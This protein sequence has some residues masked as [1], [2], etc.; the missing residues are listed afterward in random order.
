MEESKTPRQPADEAG[1]QQPMDEARWQIVESLLRRLAC[2]LTRAADGRSARLDD[3]LEETR[4]CLRKPSEPPVLEE[5]LTRLGEAIKALDEPAAAART[6]A[7][8]SPG[9]A[10]PLG[11]IVQVL[12]DLLDRLELDDAAEE[13]DQLRGAL[14][15]VRDQTALAAQVEALA[16]LLNRHCVRLGQQR[17][18][19]EKLLQQ[20]NEQLDE[21]AAFLVD[22]NQAHQSGMDSRQA[23]DSGVMGEMRALKDNVQATDDLGALRKGVELRIGAVTVHLQQFRQREEQRE[24]EWQARNHAMSERIT[25]LEHSTGELKTSLRHEQHLAA[26]DRLTGVA[27]RLVFEQR[28][29]EACAKVKRG[30]GEASLLVLDIDRFKQIND[31]LGHAAGDRALR[32]VAQQ[33]AAQLRPDDLLARYGGEEFVA[34]LARTG[35]DEA[36]QVAERLRQCI[37]RLGFHSRQQ[38]VRITLCCG[39]TTLRPGDTPTAAFDRADQALYRAKRAGRNRSEAL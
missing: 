3:Q 10:A 9:E 38:P 11:A 28:I 34:V 7:G 22:E 23:M 31:N 18:A 30:E 37:E 12:L 4:H 33:L 29:V 15:Q 35:K 5:L 21:L 32:V 6:R 25:E 36:L 39:V 19:A 20:V 17:A 24:R 26:T 27:N 16:Q 14:S 13:L 2:C 1:T 8:G